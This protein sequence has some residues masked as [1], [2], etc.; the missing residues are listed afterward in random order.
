M[1]DPAANKAGPQTSAPPLPPLP[2]LLSGQKALVTGANSG[3]GM[4]VALALAEAGADVG[5]NYVVE[6]EKAEEVA[7]QARAFGVNAGIYKADVS[8]EAEV[9]AMFA[10]FVADHGALD[11]LVANAG[12]Q[13]DASIADM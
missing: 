6:P 1:T 2:K 12:L 4:A 11:I 13:R 8:N 7:V 3:I 5:V 9:K 10:S